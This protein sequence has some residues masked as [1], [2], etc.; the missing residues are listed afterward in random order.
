LLLLD[1][2]KRGRR[3]VV[4]NIAPT[5]ASLFSDIGLFA[6]RRFTVVDTF[7]LRGPVMID[8]GGC[9]I[10]VARSAAVEVCVD[11]DE[12]ATPKP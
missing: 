7:P 4:K 8:L 5:N 9:L 11:P 3:Y 6:G 12:Q 10:A 1:A 2:C